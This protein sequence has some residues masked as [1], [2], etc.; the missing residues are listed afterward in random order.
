MYDKRN[1]REND[2]FAK[3][4]SSQKR[5]IIIQKWQDYIREQFY[6]DREETTVILLKRHSSKYSIKI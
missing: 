6:G 5:T 4:I 1:R 3:C 2:F